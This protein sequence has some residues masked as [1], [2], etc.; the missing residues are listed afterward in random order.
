MREAYPEV[1][2]ARFFSDSMNDLPLARL[3]K[4]AFLV[5]GD[6]IGPYPIK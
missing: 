4:S 3:A 2:I 1:Q 6:E 5:K